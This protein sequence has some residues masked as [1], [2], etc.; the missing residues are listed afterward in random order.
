MSSG[1]SYRGSVRPAT[2]TGS[3]TAML[4]RDGTT[5]QKSVFDKMR[6]EL[7]LGAENSLMTNGS[8]NGRGIPIPQSDS[9]MRDV[10]EGMGKNINDVLMQTQSIQNKYG[11]PNDKSVKEI[12]DEFN[13]EQTKTP[14]YVAPKQTVADRKGYTPTPAPKPKVKVNYNKNKP[15]AVKSKPSRTP[16]PKPTRTTGSRGGRGNVSARRRLTGGR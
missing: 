9:I 3:V 11:N 16:A 10:G 14:V 1:S 5:E 15:V 4:G 6:A 8:P 13:A 7:G 12:M 2:N